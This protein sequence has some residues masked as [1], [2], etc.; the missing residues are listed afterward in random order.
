MLQHLIN[1]HLTPL[2]CAVFV[3]HIDPG[4]QFVSGFFIKYCF[5]IFKDTLSDGNHRGAIAAF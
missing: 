5:H 2:G 3:K 1:I 4:N